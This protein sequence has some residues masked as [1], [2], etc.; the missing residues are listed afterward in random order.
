MSGW[1]GEA[2]SAG[3]RVERACAAVGRSART[4]QRWRQAGAIQGDAR[5]R[6][7]RAPD[8]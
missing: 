5:G 2:V 1:I 4:L 3:A 8:C 6:E 7:H